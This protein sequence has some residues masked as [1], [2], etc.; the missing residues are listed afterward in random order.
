MLESEETAIIFSK[1]HILIKPLIDIKA[2]TTIN[3]APDNPSNAVVKATTA[4]VITG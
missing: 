1:G 4:F 3:A 2:P